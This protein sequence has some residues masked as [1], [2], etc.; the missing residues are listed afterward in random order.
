MKAGVILKSKMKFM[1]S[2]LKSKDTTNYILKR[3][4]YIIVFN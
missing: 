1:H 3:L 2:L 4:Y